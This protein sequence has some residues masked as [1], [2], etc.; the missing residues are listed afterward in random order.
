MVK[1]G[2]RRAIVDPRI[3]RMSV[4]TRG[5]LPPPPPSANWYAGVHSWGMLANDTV[6]DCVEAAGMHCLLQFST[7]TGKALVPTDAETIA[8]Y[9]ATGYVPGNDATDQGSYVLGQDGMVPYWQSHGVVC[10]GRLNKVDGFTQIRRKNPMEWMQGIYLFGGMMVGLR[11]PE[12]IVA[13]AAIPFVWNDYSGPIAGG[14]EVWVNG[15][16]SVGGARYYDLVS[17]GAMYRMTEAFMLNCVDEVVCVV[18]V[19]EINSRGVNAAGFSLAQLIAD[20]RSV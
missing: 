14:H 9:E 19:A 6:G 13:D 20:M 17:W 2:K 5:R 12:V 16:Q 1:L 10:G 8:W 11:L 18:D 15:Y 7:Y 3:P 4:L